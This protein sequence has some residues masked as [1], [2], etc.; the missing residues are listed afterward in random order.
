MNIITTD[1]VIMCE[2]TTGLSNESDMVD[3]LTSVVYITSK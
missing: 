3:D 2:M 1:D